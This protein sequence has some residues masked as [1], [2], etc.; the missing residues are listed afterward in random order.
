MTIKTVV[1]TCHRVVAGERPEALDGLLADNVVFHSP[2]VAE[3]DGW[4]VRA[5]S[6]TPEGRDHHPNR[7]SQFTSV[8]GTWF[9]VRD[10][11]GARCRSGCQ[12]G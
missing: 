12:R 7:K 5:R 11:E 8:R 2:I 1:E 10:K 6:A 3:S 4:T 9:A